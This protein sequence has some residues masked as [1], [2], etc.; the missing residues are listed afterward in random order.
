MNNSTKPQDDLVAFRLES[1]GYFK[2]DRN[3]ATHAHSHTE[4]VY[5]A[6]GQC[7]SRFGNGLNTRN[8][9][10][11]LVFLI[12]PHLPH[13]QRG[14]VHT[15]FMEFSLPESAQIGNLTLIDL[16]NDP[17]IRKWFD[18]LFTLWLTDGRQEANALA[19]A[20]F[21]RCLRYRQ[22]QE[23]MP[24]PQSIR[25]QDALTFISYNFRL[26]L[27]AQD[28]AQHVQCSVNT[29][30]GYFHRQ[31]NQSMMAYLYSFRLG[32]ARQLLQNDYLSIKEIADRCGF[33]DVNYFIRAFKKHYGTTPGKNRK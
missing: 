5:V 7:T 16:R 6:D 19:Q 27:T 1:I 15:F 29:L 14:N 2:G 22:Q 25:F 23:T 9:S 33:A 8:G 31:F 17:F 3:I 11:G 32:I 12:P 24:R 21:L 10:A 26:P 20:I 18:D 30:N 13:D 4:L 28:I